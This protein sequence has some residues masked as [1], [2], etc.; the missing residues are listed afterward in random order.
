MTNITDPMGTGDGLGDK[1]QNLASSASSSA[2]GMLSSA[3]DMILSPLDGQMQ[4]LLGGIAG[5]GMTGQLIAQGIAQLYSIIRPGFEFA[6]AQQEASN[7]IGLGTPGASAGSGGLTPAAA[8]IAQAMGGM[9]GVSVSSGL[10]P[11]AVT[12]FGNPS[13]HGLGRAVDLVGTPDQMRGVWNALLGRPGIQ[14]LIYAGMA[15]YNGGPPV[16]FTGSNKHYDHVH[17]GVGDG[18][19]QAGSSPSSRSMSMDNRVNL[20]IENMTVSNGQTAEDF[21]DELAEHLERLN[22]SSGSVDMSEMVE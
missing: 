19:G 7:A 11:G 4:D 12:E 16:P 5:K 13:L 6:A 21:V 14:E 8:G 2:R 3:T 18:V 17:V 9:F 15:S 1:V 10:R 22:G 20:R